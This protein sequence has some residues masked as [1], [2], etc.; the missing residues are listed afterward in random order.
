MQTDLARYQLADLAAVSP[1]W[2]RQ[3]GYAW[4]LERDG[5]VIGRVTWSRA[6]GW[7]WQ[8]A[9]ARR[10]GSAVCAEDARSAVEALL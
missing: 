7:R 10:Q 4:C 6:A 9:D 8:S 2:E 3:D 5:T 1:R